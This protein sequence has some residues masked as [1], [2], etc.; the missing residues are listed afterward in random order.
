M[1]RIYFDQISELR[2]WYAGQMVP[3]I[4]GK[5]L[6]LSAPVQTD[7]LSMEFFQHLSALSEGTIRDILL[8]PLEELCTQYDWIREYVMLCDATALYPSL[9]QDHPGHGVSGTRAEYIDKF[10]DCAFF[11]QALQDAGLSCKAAAASWDNMGRVIHRATW[12]RRLLDSVITQKFKYSFL[13][14]EL[15][16]ELVKKMGVPVCPYCNQQ[17]ILKLFYVGSFMFH[18]TFCSLLRSSPRMSLRSGNTAEGETDSSS[19][20]IRRK[21]SV[22]VGSAPNSPQ[23]PT[24]Q[25]CRCPASTVCRIIRRTAG[26]WAS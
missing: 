7:P 26:W 9:R 23:M 12:K 6:R 20:P 18:C 16:G 13:S 3:L 4:H 21:V 25:P 10:R 22:S 24:Q 15:R 2:T 14:D 5:R 11:Q 17:Y 1:I 19:N 8:T